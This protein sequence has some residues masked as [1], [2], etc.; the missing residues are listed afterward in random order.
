MGL[1][2]AS[3]CWYTHAHMI[4]RIRRPDDFHVHVRQ[5]PALERY[6]ADLSAIFSRAIIMPNTLP[7]ISDAHGLENYRAQILRAAASV[8]GGFEPLMTFKIMPS[9]AEN[10]DELIARLKSAGAV[11]GKLY[12]QGVT[13]NSSDGVRDIETMYPVFSAM[14][15]LGVI[16]CVHGEDPDAF[17]LDREAAFLPQLTR[18]VEAF[19]KLKI[20]LE[21][22]S[23]RAAAE[24]VTKMPPRVGATI[25]VHHLLFTLDDMLG[26]HLNPH[27]FCKPLIKTPGDREALV[28]AALS[29]SPKFFFGSDSAP[30]SKVS[31][32]CDCGAA[33]VYSMP[34]SLPLLAGFFEA[35]GKLD[36]LENF[37]SRYGAEFYGLP[38]SGQFV[39]LE[40]SSWEVPKVLHADCQDVDGGVVPL[41][42]GTRLDWRIKTVKGRNYGDPSRN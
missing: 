12:P 5:G 2:S 4:L 26:G 9:I 19:P 18:V 37:V 15:R 42:A 40:R 24:W 30:H 27:L 17:C 25:T 7:P 32:E 20:V 36:L 14:E 38:L 22:V 6:V 11:A 34:V 39:E 8:D 28:N 35:E 13:T 21:H 3:V 23:T 1:R 31:K 41:G 33:G 16:F 29:G 10:A